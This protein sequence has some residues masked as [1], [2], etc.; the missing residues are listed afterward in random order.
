M[1]ISRVRRLDPPSPGSIGMRGLLRLHIPLSATRLLNMAPQ[2]ITVL[3]VGRSLQPELSLA[4]WPTIYGLVALF[5]G[6]T[7]DLESVTAAHQPHRSRLIAW[8][9]GYVAV[10]FTAGFAIVALTPLCWWY[11]ADL[12]GVPRAAA[13]VGVHWTFLLLAA[14]TLWVV[15]SYL[16]GVVVAEGTVPRLVGSA[17]AHV[18]VLTAL[19]V[20]LPWWGA[21]GVVSASI[22]LVGGLVVETTWTAWIVLSTRTTVPAVT[23]EVG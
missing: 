18:V 12:V 11:V 17:A 10:A 3:A 7:A 2:L 14:P 5:T 23:T 20:L 4:V 9:T 19:C 22:A 15:R 1:L 16:R 8:L 6:P 13:I 21:P